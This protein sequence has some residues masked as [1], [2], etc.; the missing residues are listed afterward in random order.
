MTWIIGRI[1]SGEYRGKT[2][3]V[4]F[5]KPLKVLCAGKDITN[6]TME[7]HVSLSTRGQIIAVKIAELD[8]SQFKTKK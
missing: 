7:I 2:I 6:V 8:Y 5:G 4:K 3:K 1:E